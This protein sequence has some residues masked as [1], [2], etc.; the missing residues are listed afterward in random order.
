MPSVVSNDEHY[1]SKEKSSFASVD[2]IS[3]PRLVNQYD[4]L[5]VSEK[6]YNQ[7]FNEVTYTS[8]EDEKFV[9]IKLLGTP[10]YFTEFKLYRVSAVTPDNKMSVTFVNHSDFTSFGTNLTINSCIIRSVRKADI[11]ALSKV[12]ISTPPLMYDILKGKTT[13]SVRH[14]IF[15]KNLLPKGSVTGIGS[16]IREV[17]GYVELCEPFNQGFA[18]ENT[19]IILIKKDEQGDETSPEE[20]EDNS[21]I[22]DLDVSRYLSSSLD[23]SS[24]VFNPSFKVRPLQEKVTVDE[25]PDTHIKED[26]DLYAFINTEDFLKIGFPLFNGNNVKLLY[27]GGKAIVRVFTF[28]EPHKSFEK[29]SVYLSPILILN[30]GLNE[31]DTVRFEEVEQKDKPLYS[32]LP[33][34][35]SAT[36]ARVASP[37]TMDKTYQQQFFSEL[38]STLNNSLKCVTQNGLIPVLID[39]VLAKSL[40]D[41]SNQIQQR[42]AGGQM[43]DDDIFDELGIIPTGDPD[44][45]A[46]FKIT[47][48]VSDDA[49]YKETGQYIIDPSKTRLISSGIEYIRLPENRFSQWH[50][51]LQL[52]PVFDY[53]RAI[54]NHHGIFQYYTELKN[55]L[56][57]CMKSNSTI[58]LKTSVLLNS[59]TRGLGKTTLIRS[60][61]L[62]MGINL[63]E[64]DCL[65]LVNPGAELKTIGILKGKIDKHLNG[66]SLSNDSDVTPAFHV[67]YVKHVEAICASSNQNDQNSNIITSLA[68][69]VTQTLNE[70]L[71]EYSNLMLIISCNDID[72]LNDSLR[73]SIKFQI[74]L[75]VPEESERL[76]IFKFV[77]ENES[78]RATMYSG[79][80]QEST[81]PVISNIGFIKRRDVNYESLALQSA[82]LT[83]RDIIAIV[84]QA[85][86]VALARVKK[87]AESFGIT[88]DKL[89]EIGYGNIINWIPEDFNLSINDARNQFSDSIG[90]PRIPNVKW[91]DVGGLDLVKDEIMDT[92]D[93][94]LKHPE[95]FANGL[96]KRSG[97]LFYGP[98]GTGKTL[99]AKAIATNFSLNFFS[100]KGPELLNM[101]IG[102][103]EA[104]VRRV[105]Q[106]ARDAKPCVIFF[107]ELDSVAPKRGN[108]G[109]SGGV[110]DRIVSQLLAEL[111][112]MSGGENSSGGV[113]VVG[114]TNR[115]DLL[116][117]A[118]L[119]PG[120]FDKMVYLGI[121]DTDEKQAK[122]LEALTRKFTL[123]SDVDLNAL[124]S[125]CPFTFTGADFYALCSDA[126][127]NAMTRIATDV[128][129]KIALYNEECTKSGKSEITTRWW[130]DNVATEDDIKVVVNMGDFEKAKQDLTPSVSAE[131]LNHYLRVRENFEGGKKKANQGALGNGNGHSTSQFEMNGNSVPQVDA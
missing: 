77:I 35:K 67:L 6:L 62:H 94:P 90:A 60:L 23:I 31:N 14:V 103:S 86:S 85:K 37:V 110:M 108:Q 30:L 58:K 88:V 97:I 74:D 2:F 20:Y 92:I 116:D 38:K 11:V 27:N 57:T 29:G 56:T 101:Y 46:W 26:S 41:T 25:L 16:R 54:D 1:V 119:R 10:D 55:I 15:N 109:D 113:F 121:S 13:S 104:N 122:I 128:D 28:L 126:M 43:P 63:I 45:V 59:S 95:L 83:P 123:G 68:L 105:F 8:N 71:E 36:I 65:E 40:F 115:P 99:L 118:L 117:E 21:E 98:P 80:R 34:A 9:L 24:E 39:T 89:I 19:E 22:F 72:K 100:V 33:T 73:S 44:D 75:N 87:M 49:P 78:K 91:E 61:A 42:S 84:K 129:K 125:K 130:F 69:K 5:L 12:F 114:A 124:S 64:I 53:S 76:E 120:R 131:E 17:K 79:L 93:M 102:E 107:D 66:Q 47:E 82:G 32:F 70:Y 51:F 48:V 112:G 52:P 81:V 3:D 18:N 127:L 96:K 4:Q 50:S 111:D 7:L 106:R